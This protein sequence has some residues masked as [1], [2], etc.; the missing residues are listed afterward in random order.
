VNVSSSARE[1][2]G[3][4]VGEVERRPILR[5]V[6][7]VARVVAD[8]KRLH[9][10]TVKIDGWVEQ[11]FVAVTGQEVVRGEPLLTIYS[12]ELLSS[13]V[14]YLTARRAAEKLLASDDP[15]LEAA[16]SELLASARRRLELWDISDAQIERLER[17]GDAE[18]YLTIHAPASGV[19][20]ERN[21][22]P[23][24]RVMPGAV[25]MTVADLGA[26]WADASIYE[27]DLP[28]VRV[29]MP[30]ELTLPY[31]PGKSF[32]GE[33]IFVSP[34]VDPATRT[35]VARL[36]VPNRGLLLKPGMY[37]DA[38][39]LYDLG[40]CLTIP[41]SAVMF[42]GTRVYAFRDEGGGRLVPVEIRIGIRG[43]GRYE[44]ISGLSE[45]DRVVTSANFLI[46]SESSLEYALKSLTRGAGAPAQGH[47]AE[48]GRE[49]ASGGAGGAHVH[50]H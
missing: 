25:L 6:R 38:R 48:P 32:T 16:A 8:E 10:V 39:L 29:G 11:L 20:L 17:T 47:G 21:V 45:G 24:E 31:W 3:L 46:D 44:L 40:E 12:P 7:T 41:E 4:T 13:Q 5:E 50:G 30:F 1:R 14:E 37:G 35:L 34:T 33:V 19:V 42:A 9:R 27:S 49:G 15:S 22:L 2:I 43:E 36:A 23:G 28:F 18:K 26:V